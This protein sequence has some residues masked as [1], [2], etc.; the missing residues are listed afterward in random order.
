MWVIRVQ[1]FQ[2]RTPTMAR[3]VKCRSEL[4]EHLRRQ[5]TSHPVKSLNRER[6]AL[7]TPPSSSQVQWERLVRGENGLCKRGAPSIPKGDSVATVLSEEGNQESHAVRI[8]AKPLTLDLQTQT[9]NFI[10]GGVK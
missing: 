4:L 7:R 9:I 6:G 5:N 10:I 8:K 1:A 3:L 2:R